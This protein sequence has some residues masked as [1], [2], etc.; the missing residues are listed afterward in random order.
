MHLTVPPGVSDPCKDVDCGKCGTC[1][2]TGNRAA[3][4]KC[5]CNGEF[6]GKNCEISKTHITLY[7]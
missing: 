5:Q 3:P 7:S 6:T 2:R 1:I 4:Y